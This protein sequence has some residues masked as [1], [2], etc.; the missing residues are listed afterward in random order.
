MK[1]LI[2]VLLTTAFLLFLFS[3]IVNAA[4]WDPRNPPK[5]PERPT[6]EVQPTGDD[7]PFGVDKSSKLRIIWIVLSYHIFIVDSHSET[8]VPT[9]T[10]TKG[11]DGL[12][13]QGQGT[14]GQPAIPAGNR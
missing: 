13:L 4:L 10:E 8:P 9:T 6:L 5:F 14:S 12:H 7:D 1:R 11:S 3:P 2:L